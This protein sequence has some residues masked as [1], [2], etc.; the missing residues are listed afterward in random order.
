[1]KDFKK[2][3]FEG[4]FRGNPSFGGK[5]DRFND[6]DTRPSFNKKPWNKGPKSFADKPMFSTTCSNCG[7]PCEVPF[8]PVDGRP[9][10]CKDCFEKGRDGAAPARGSFNSQPERHD[11]RDDRNFAPA[12][13]SNDFSQDRAPKQSADPR[14]DIV[15]KQLEK[16]SS[17]LDRLIGMMVKPGSEKQISQIPSTSKTSSNDLSELAPTVK[18]VTADAKAP[19]KSKTSTAAKP[20]VASKAPVSKKA[21]AKKK[22]SKKK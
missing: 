6:R 21:G 9:V 12:A 5:S 11:R 7:K 3:G 14:I 18:K 2:G 15:V 17:Q 4:G 22:S 20:V 1:M 10:F 16:V 13:R 8:R 19:A